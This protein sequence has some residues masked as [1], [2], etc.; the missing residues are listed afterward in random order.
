MTDP[1]KLTP[2]EQVHRG[3]F[4][5]MHI[6]EVADELWPDLV[7]HIGTD[8][9]D[10]SL[11]LYFT[12][13]TPADLS[14]TSEQAR[15]VFELGFHRFWLNFCDGTEQYCHEGLVHQRKPAAMARGGSKSTLRPRLQKR[16]EELETS[17]KKLQSEKISVLILVDLVRQALSGDLSPDERYP[18]KPIPEVERILQLRGR[19]G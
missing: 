17:V 10:N 8:H 5:E 15:R 4:A 16:V 3:T 1:H 2:A 11:E 18:G 13:Q 19:T 12:E 7:G 14:C 9:Y 6:E